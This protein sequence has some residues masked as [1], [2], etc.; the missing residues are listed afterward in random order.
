MGLFFGLFRRFS[1]V[2]CSAIMYLTVS[3]PWQPETPAAFRS[4][5]GRVNGAADAKFTSQNRSRRTN[6]FPE[7][8]GRARR[9]PKLRELRANTRQNR[10]DG[11]PRSAGNQPNAPGQ[12]VPRAVIGCARHSS[13]A[14][15]P[16]NFPPLTPGEL[17]PVRPAF[18]AAPKGTG[19]P[20]HQGR[21]VRGTRINRTS[22]GRAGDPLFF[23]T[24][25]ASVYCHLRFQTSRKFPFFGNSGFGNF[26]PKHH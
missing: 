1:H 8:Q 17:S 11:N 5:F 15:A 9:K 13:S 2:G 3:F 16:L 25:Q 6:S 22:Q 19:P 20:A 14:H 21:H 23:H 26:P 4:P 7:R 24:L 12:R 18:R 10:V